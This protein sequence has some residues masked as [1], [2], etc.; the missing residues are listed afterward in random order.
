MARVILSLDFSWSIRNSQNP[1]TKK[2]VRDAS[3]SAVRESV[4]ASPSTARK[5][6]ARIDNATERK[7]LNATNINSATV[8]IPKIAVLRRQPVD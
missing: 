6:P 7:S 4:I 8:A 5:N 2:N 1:N 3:K